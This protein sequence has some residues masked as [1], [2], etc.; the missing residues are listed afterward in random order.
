MVWCDGIYLYRSVI[1]KRANGLVHL[2]PDGRILTTSSGKR[3]LFSP[4]FGI[5]LCRSGGGGCYYTSWNLRSRVAASSHFT[6][7]P[8]IRTAGKSATILPIDRTPDSLGNINRFMSVHQPSSSKYCVY[9]WWAIFHSPSSPDGRS[10]AAYYSIS[11]TDRGRDNPLSYSFS[12][13]RSIGC[14]LGCLFDFFFPPA[15]RFGS[16]Y[17][18]TT[19]PRLSVQSWSYKV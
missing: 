2:L 9:L 3:K 14:L 13:F 18:L 5:L 17:Y 1:T 8:P 15:A 12:V 19:I 11:T 6:F 16:S 7:L 10:I 4:P